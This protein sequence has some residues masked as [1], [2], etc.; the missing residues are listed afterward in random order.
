MLYV[1]LAS[2]VVTFA[3]SATCYNEQLFVSVSIS[4]FES[5]SAEWIRIIPPSA[6]Q[7]QIGSL[8]SC[9]PNVL[10]CFKCA[11]MIFYCANVLV[12]LRSAHLRENIVGLYCY[13]QDENG[14]GYP[15][16]LVQLFLGTILSRHLAYTSPVRLSWEMPRLLVRSMLSYVQGWS[17]QFANLLVPFQ[18]TR[19]TR[20]SQRTLSNFQIVTPF[21]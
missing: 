8:F 1:L 12:V 15:P 20:V 19:S 3:R 4:V 13:D 9:F 17:P 6:H 18:N 10:K 21:L 11:R 2:T 7:I 5:E 16:T 14:T